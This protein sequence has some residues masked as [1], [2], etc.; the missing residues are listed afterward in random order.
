M[1]SSIMLR[2]QGVVSSGASTS[3]LESGI[4]A[5]ALQ[6]AINQYPDH[7]SMLNPYLNDV[8][9]TIAPSLTND[10]ANAHLPLDRFSIAN[11]LL[12]K[13][14][15]PSSLTANESLA[16]S[17]LT[18]SF[19]LQ[20]RNPANGLW[21]YVYPEWS[22]L[23][24]MFSV[25]PFMASQP[26]PNYID[27]SLQISL[28]KQHC[29]HE[30]GLLVHGYDYSKTA[31]WANPITGGSQFV[32]GRSLG[33][34]LSGL[35]QTWEILCIPGPHE[36]GSKPDPS[37]STSLCAQIQNTFTALASP[38][39]SFADPDTGAWWQMT[40]FPGRQGNYLES[41]S[42]LLFTFSLLKAVRL[43]LLPSAPGPGPGLAPAPY[44][45]LQP[46]P[47]HS[48]PSS[49]PS[50]DPAFA[51]G[52][53]R[54]DSTTNTITITNL[55]SFSKLDLNDNNLAV[56]ARAA[57]LKAYHYTTTSSAFLTY[58][59]NPQNETIGL[60]KTVSVCSLNS[61]ANYT[62]YTTRPIMMDSALGEGAFVLASLEAEML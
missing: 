36:S 16:L 26:N 5:L 3:T 51:P 15:L 41:S 25:L 46:S 62:Y 10:T 50:F 22:Y 9:S 35:V 45:S 42:T 37:A 2:E 55:H 59:S 57:A 14:H 60:D 39:L 17:A 24:G 48:T 52:R 49:R 7:S 4:L 11:A 29:A 44:P 23:D 47:T 12:T 38:L 40:T 43:N 20:L 32:W 30:S 61:T 53:Q 31:V 28:L 58:S 54:P 27:L 34:F 13:S 56:Q 18:N 1:L 33:W 21:Y 6:S 19:P 8:L